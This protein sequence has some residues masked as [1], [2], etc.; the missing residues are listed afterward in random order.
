MYIHIRPLL[1]I[2]LVRIK[3]APPSGRR[4]L[5]DSRAYNAGARL[6]PVVLEEDSGA[7]HGEP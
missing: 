1:F 4:Q 6:M 3:P 5:G 2:G 7:D